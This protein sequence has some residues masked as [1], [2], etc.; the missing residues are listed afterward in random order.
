[1]QL[2]R[3]LEEVAAG[4]Q[5]TTNDLRNDI[6]VLIRAVRGQGLRG[7]LPAAEGKRG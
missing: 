3:L 2:L 7:D 1:V 5:E 6:K 4:R